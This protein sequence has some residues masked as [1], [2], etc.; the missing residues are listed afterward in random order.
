MSEEERTLIGIKLDHLRE[1]MELKFEEINK[2]DKGVHERLDKINGQV[3]KNSK[4]CDMYADEV[5]KNT[6]F[7]RSAKVWATV[8]VVFLGFLA[9]LL[10]DILSNILNI[11]FQ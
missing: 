6:Q 3:S 10:R 8:I 11:N 9:P 7:R 1:L 5:P 2:N 4:F